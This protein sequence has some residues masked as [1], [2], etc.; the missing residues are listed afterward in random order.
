MKTTYLHRLDVTTKLI[1]F[2]CVIV[3]VFIFNHPLANL[4]LT[5][6]LL[7][8]ILP[9]RLELKP[10]FQT[11]S[12]LR[13]I[14]VIIL[15]I[16]CFSAQTEKFALESSKTVLFR[17]IGLNATV[18]GLLQGL[19]FILRIFTMVLVTSAFTIS[20]PIDDLL[21]FFSKVKAPYELSVVVATA[22]SFVPTMMQKKDQI[23]QA[24]KSRGAVIRQKGAIQQ[25][26]SFFPI[27]IPLVTNSILMADNLSISMTNRGYG[28]NRTWTNMNETHPTTKDYIVASVAV[29][30]TVVLIVARS[31]WRIGII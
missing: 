13:L 17:I 2:L 10:V 18:G 7:A 20:T 19:T 26:I 4:L 25:I 14:L 22:I 9:A 8:V 3:A 16:T 11:L 15:I 5:L 1:V 21:G 6:S 29:L 24:Q 31:V 28:A 12:A 23:F 30:M 27:M